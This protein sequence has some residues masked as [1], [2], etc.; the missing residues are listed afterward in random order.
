MAIIFAAT[1]DILN[2]CGAGDMVLV[3]SCY[4]SETCPSDH[5]G[6]NCTTNF[7]KCPHLFQIQACTVECNR[8]VA[9]SLSLSL[10]LSLKLY[11][12]HSVSLFL[13]LSLSLIVS[14]SLSLSICVS[15]SLSLSLLL[16]LSISMSHYIYLSL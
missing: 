2:R 3:K 13:Y 6:I 11:F 15:L 4:F 7:F 16:C 12:S 14:F 10:S 9:L 1:I 8:A 5:L